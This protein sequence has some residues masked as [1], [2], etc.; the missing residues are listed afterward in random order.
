MNV[1]GSRREMMEARL[2]ETIWTF[3]RNNIK[4]I[5]ILVMFFYPSKFQSWL[6]GWMTRW[7]KY[8]QKWTITNI[9]LSNNT[10]LIKFPITAITWGRVEDHHNSIFLIIIIIIN[11]SINII[12]LLLMNLS[13]S[14]RASK[15]KVR[16]M[17]EIL[18][19]DNCHSPLQNQNHHRQSRN[20]WR[21]SIQIRSERRETNIETAVKLDEAASREWHFHHQHHTMYKVFFYCFALKL[22]SI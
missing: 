7:L 19:Q 18:R 2:S 4:P 22:L 17:K 8:S 11:I 10:K 9:I 16:C 3:I 6:G 5:K 15:L 1:V 21:S 12:I 20:H 14:K 13:I